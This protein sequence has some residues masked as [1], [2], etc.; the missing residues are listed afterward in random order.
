MAFAG[1]RQRNQYLN[2]SSYPVTDLFVEDP[3]AQMLLHRK[4]PWDLRAG[5]VG[6]K[7]ASSRLDHRLPNR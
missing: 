3:G 1:A 6:L 4:H 5:R 7:A 2:H